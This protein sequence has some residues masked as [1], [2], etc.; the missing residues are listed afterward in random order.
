MDSSKK[1]SL[2]RRLRLACARWWRTLAVVAAVAACVGVGVLTQT[3]HV[4]LFGEQLLRQFAILPTTAWFPPCDAAQPCTESSDDAVGA[5]M[6]LQ[7]YAGLGNRLRALVS[8]VLL[9]DDL[10]RRL[11][12]WWDDLDV[13]C[14]I[15]AHRVMNF[16]PFASQIAAVQYSPPANDIRAARIWMDFS[17]PSPQQFLAWKAAPASLLVLDTYN[18]FY[19]VDPGRWLATLASVSPSA[20]VAARLND[21]LTH[22]PLLPRGYRE[23]S[24][25]P[26]RDCIGVHVRRGDHG[27]DGSGAPQ[28]S[29]VALF[30][31]AMEVASSEWSS[32]AAFLVAS[33]DPTIGREWQQRSRLGLRV[34]NLAAHRPG[35]S[36]L[37]ADRSD[38]DSM[39]WAA[40]DMFALS[41]CRAVIGSYY[42]SFSV[43]AAARAGISLLLP[44]VLFAADNVTGRLEEL[45]TQ[46]AVKLPVLLR[47]G[48]PRA[49]GETAQSASP[50]P[51]AHGGMLWWLPP[52]PGLGDVAQGDV[53]G[54]QWPYQFQ[55]VQVLPA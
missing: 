23:L 51:L 42:S 41:T 8:A 49:G 20:E 45:D 5:V 35:A 9:A 52:Q 26:R 53:N 38:T 34:H 22:I 11:V 37:S 24:S 13:N 1:R 40:V 44:R 46:R 54:C 19:R 2:R 29:P 28:H 32:S 10:D 14:G 3:P 12:V 47:C 16:T 21:A 50:F 27:N 4:L 18:S 48:P 36:A 6:H 15:Q 43:L 25:T 17:M 7:P 30:L 55:S 39:I 33:D 31:A